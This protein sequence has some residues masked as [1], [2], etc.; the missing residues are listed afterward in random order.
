MDGIRRSVAIG[1]VASAA[2]FAAGW[3]T[4]ARIQTL[5]AA[6]GWVQ[7]TQNTR[8]VL[9]RTLSSL[10]DAE[11]TS[12]GYA[13]TRD[14]IFLPPYRAS[15]VRIEADLEELKE[16]VAHNPTQL[17]H[18]RELERLIRTRLEPMDRGFELVQRGIAEVPRERLA[19]AQL[20]GNALMATV[21]AQAAVMH[22]EEERLLNE[23]LE[24]VSGARDT[25]ML[26]SG[27]TTALA[28]AL[29]LLILVLEN[30]STRR[31]RAS[32][33]WLATTLRSIG[34][35]VI[36][37][38]ERGCVK[39]LNP[40]ASQLTGWSAEEARTRTLDE[41]LPL[42]SEDSG[43]AV[44]NPVARVLREGKIVGLANH[45][46]LVRRDGTSV[47][48]E[49]SGAPIL[50]ERGTT[51]GVVMVFRDASAE[52][53]AAQKLAANEERLR[54]A[55]EGAELGTWDI[56]LA[57]D[58]LVL[59]EQYERILGFGPGAEVT[60]ERVRERIMP[61][62]RDLVMQAIER[63]RG[64]KEPFHIEYRIVRA[65]D[66]SERWVSVL[67][68][69]LF[70]EE[71]KPSRIIGIVT[72][73]TERRRLEQ[74]VRQAQ[75]L[76]ALGTLAG[77]IAHDFNNILSIMRGNLLLIE[78]DLP[79]GDPIA[80]AISEMSRACSRARDLVRQ[81]LTFG[82]QQEQDRKI[83]SLTEVIEEAVKL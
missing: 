71:G 54:L 52:R 3:I 44:E 15:L 45:T 32:E 5:D 2:L 13:V 42:L 8:L 59:N 40:V 56:D 38:D 65:N 74:R 76:D 6:A 67:G 41:I 43:H 73:I 77:G 61:E 68:R 16:R 46:L 36:A 72:D 70:D 22:R 27:G 14:E 51:H 24:A 78:A 30:R 21:R 80:P 82:R 64:N 10:K 75:K 26:V 83:V 39:Y 60:R 11:T 7:R 55:T 12:R 66:S 25:A 58:R 4:V 49:D 48:I 19:R 81:I 34:D 35:A 17:A 28:A 20:E 63:A 33:E 29:V 23:Q 31:L 1:I 53:A 18:T 79:P 9:E 37:T 47:A 50:D 57:T 62:D 69:Y